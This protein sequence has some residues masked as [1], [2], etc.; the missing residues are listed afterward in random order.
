MCR[1]Q[2]YG[3]SCRRTSSLL[4]AVGLAFV[5]P[6]SWV[7]NSGWYCDVSTFVGV[8]LIFFLQGL[9]LPTDELRRGYRPKRLHGFILS[10]NFLFFPLLTGLVLS[11]CGPYFGTELQLGFGLLAILPTTVASATAFSALAGGHTGN[12]LFASL[13][14]NALAVW[15][16]PA[17]AVSYLSLEAG[18]SIAV[19]PIFGQ[20]GLLILLPLVLGQ[21]VRRVAPLEAAW[22]ASRTQWLSPAI[23]ALMVHLAFARS[24]ASG[25][26]ETLAFPVLLAVLAVCFALLWI[27]SG[28]VWWSSVFLRCTQAQRITCFF[29]ASQKS[30]AT[31]LPLALSILAAVGTSLD[32][33]VILIPLLCYHPLQLLWAAWISQR[34][35]NG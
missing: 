35:Q 29:C 5:V 14:S 2:Q 8:G 31:G 34:W 1:I 18:T 4:L 24:I 12:A 16:V 17:L 25:L 9:S 19:G 28:L 27:V 20:L 11:Q 6:R 10:W 30:L 21:S 32:P 7:L 3:A 26:L 33:A 13:Y 23:I 22:L 15:L